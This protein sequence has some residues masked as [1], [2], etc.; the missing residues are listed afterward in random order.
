TRRPPRDPRHAVERP[1][2][3]HCGGPR[4]PKQPHQLVDP[5]QE[6]FARRRPQLPRSRDEAH[7]G[8]DPDERRAAQLQR[9]DRFRHRFPTLQV[10]LDLRLG[11]RAR[12]DA[13]N[14]A[15]GRPGEGLDGHGSNITRKS[16]RGT[17]NR[18]TQGLARLLRVPSSPFRVLVVP[19][20]AMSYQTLLF[21]I[22]DGVA[23]ITINRPDKL[24]ALNNQVVD[25]L[26]DAAERVATEDAIKG[27]ILTGAGPKAFRSEEHTSELQ[28]RFDLVCRLLLEKK[29]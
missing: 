19:F 18:A 15:G 7:R 22:K 13:A 20:S 4:G 17:W 24:N 6:A 25:E 8:R 29:T 12:V 10:A 21:E 16:E 2:Q 5:G 3:V 28:S 14:G 1:V 23:L 11:Q 26:A 27:A 9:A